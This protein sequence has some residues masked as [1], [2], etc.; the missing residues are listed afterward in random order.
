MPVLPDPLPGSFLALR[1]LRGLPVAALPSPGAL[2]RLTALRTLS[3][4]GPPEP[5]AG[6]R[7]LHA[8]NV[9]DGQA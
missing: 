2:L 1:E 3:L 9:D 4:V 6:H 8:D 5:P 7:R